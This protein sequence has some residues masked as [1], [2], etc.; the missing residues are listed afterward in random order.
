VVCSATQC[1][2]YSTANW[3]TPHIFDLKEPAQLVLQCSRGFALV[4]AVG[5]AQVGEACCPTAADA[6]DRWQ[7]NLSLQMHDLCMGC[8]NTSKLLLLYFTPV[9]G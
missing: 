7:K 4:D 8:C 9:S 3:N 1:H 6:Q 5:A 2:I